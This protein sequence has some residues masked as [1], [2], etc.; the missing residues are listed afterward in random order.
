MHILLVET[1]RKRA[2]LRRC[3]RKWSCIHAS[4]DRELTAFPAKCDHVS[5]RA[6]EIEPENVFRPVPRAV[7]HHYCYQ[8]NHVGG[9][10]DRSG[11]AD[12]QAHAG[13]EALTITL[14]HRANRGRSVW[15]AWLCLY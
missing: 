10:R 7:W 15:E 2:L 8:G 12:I 4:S 11:K 9:S 13:T 1:R 14:G 5:A 6:S 3:R